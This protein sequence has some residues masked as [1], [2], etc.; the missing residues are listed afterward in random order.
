MQKRGVVLLA[1]IQSCQYAEWETYRGACC[2]PSLRLL[3]F[4]AGRAIYA[5]EMRSLTLAE[6]DMR[7]SIRTVDKEGRI[8]CHCVVE[9]LL[10]NFVSYFG[11]SRCVI[12]SLESHGCLAHLV[13]KNDMS[14]LQRLFLH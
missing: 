13:V 5:L 3:L 9:N 6:V 11:E 10:Q 12:R 8:L 7:F 1:I 4:H 2:C 14:Y